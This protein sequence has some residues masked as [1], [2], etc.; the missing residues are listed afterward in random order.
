MITKFNNFKESDTPTTEYTYINGIKIYSRIHSI[1]E[2][3]KN[4]LSSIEYYSN[5]IS[6]ELYNL[7]IDSRVSIDDSTFEIYLTKNNKS[8]GHISLDSE[9][10]Q[11]F[12]HKYVGGKYYFKVEY[13]DEFII[14]CF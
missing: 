3:Y 13:N 10:T 1:I 5:N 9:K 7:I 14:L 2:K 6:I 8:V 11:S 4:S 12:Q